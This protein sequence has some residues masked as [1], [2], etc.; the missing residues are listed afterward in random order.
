MNPT[1]T[2]KQHFKNKEIG[3][4][5]NTYWAENKNNFTTITNFDE[6]FIKFV[7]SITSILMLLI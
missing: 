6:K 7:N 4:I 3:S 2:S 1:K 5:F